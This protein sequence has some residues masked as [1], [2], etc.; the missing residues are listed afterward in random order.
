MV[1]D[2]YL[3]LGVSPAASQEEIRTA[4]RR[5]ALELHPD[6]SGTDSEPFLELQRAYGVLGDPHRRRR[7]D[8]SGR[9][10]A[11]RS[12]QTRA[13]AEPLRARRTA[14]EPFRPLESASDVQDISLLGSFHTYGPS[15]DELVDRLLSNFGS[16]TTTKGEH[17]ESLTVDIPLTPDQTL[18][19][20]EIELMVPAQVRCPACEGHGQVGGYLCWRCGG[21]GL[22]SGEAPIRIAYPSGIRNHYVVR[23]P[24]EAYG[25]HNFYLTVRFC[26]TEEA[27]QADD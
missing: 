6:R 9:A 15:F 25:I 1:K 13:S 10:R 20:G 19:G 23:I 2:Y 11:P 24:L 4:F 8:R 18:V 7:Y 14:A 27:G 21:T 5:R 16:P 17:L 3:I 26:V 22:L 12:S